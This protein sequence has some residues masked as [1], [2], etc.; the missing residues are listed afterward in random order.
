[1]EKTGKK[2]MLAVVLW[3]V[4]PPSCTALLILWL[5]VGFAGGRLLNERTVESLEFAADQ[6]TWIVVSKVDTLMER[7]RGIAGNALTINAFVDP[8]SVEHFLSPF[9]R[10]LRFGNYDSLIIVI[11]DFSG[12]VLA[13]NQARGVLESL[14]LEDHWRE[15]VLEGNEMLTIAENSLIASVP[16]YVGNLPE[17]SLT[18]RLSP[19][20]TTELLSSEKH[21]GNVWL[22]DQD[23]RLLFGP[24]NE[25][26]ASRSDSMIVSKPAA[27]PNFPV[28][29]LVSGLPLQDEDNLVDTLHLFLLVAFLLDLV[30]LI[31]GIYTAA[32]LIANPLNRLVTKIRSIQQLTDADARLEP[33]G[34][35][36]LVNL[37]DAFNEATA[38]QTELTRRLE[39][40][41][42]REKEINGLQRE[43]VSLVSHE[44]R[45]PLSVIDGNAQRILRRMETIPRDNIRTGIEK[46][47]TSV[48]R[49]IDLMESVLSSSRLEAGTIEFKPGRCRLLDILEEA[50]E[51]QREISKDLQIVYDP[52][53]LPI[54]IHADGKL[55]RQVFSNLISNAVK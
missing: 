29:Q 3:R 37:A 55:L 36:E 7:L 15:A 53:D 21:G 28:L 4:V 46:C 35:L 38:R 44:F 47:R 25:A 39:E 10:S 33:H 19:E 23:D 31:V 41:L 32:S 6:Q 14:A 26:T 48:A 13:S 9:L 34:P 8:L 51:N 17:G 20:D 22:R 45:T 2:T 18:V 27:L 16:I 40:A 43:F 24:D 1:M 42:N 50:V 30:A 49:L 11:T 5:F 12:Q 54:D 52:G